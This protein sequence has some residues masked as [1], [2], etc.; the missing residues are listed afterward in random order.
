MTTDPGASVARALPGANPAPTTIFVQITDTHIREPGRLAYGRLDTAPYL[1]AAVAAIGAL[2]QAPQ[3]VVMTGDLSDFGR[4]EEYAHLAAL[5]APLTVPVYLIP[6]NH[7]T[8]AGLRQAFP[9]H[10]YLGVDGPIRYA[11]DIGGLR[12]LALDT[13]VP[14]KS[15]GEL[16]DGQLRWLDEELARCAGRPAV[17]AMH[18]PPFATLIGH[19]DKIGLL[20]G[21]EALERIVARH[22]HVERIIC[23]HVHRPIERRFGGTIASVCPSPAHQVC[24]DLQ[25]DAASAWI[26]EPP[27]FRVHALDPAGHLVSH[28]APIGRFDG[29]HPFHENGKLID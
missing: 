17:I 6:G 29:P 16:D 12:L 1:R 15:H 4:A 13:S 21:A 11:V 20:A 24:L 28:L 26:L 8:R 23:G 7:D 22:A 9:R 14:G 5:I 27:A 25:P 3:A 19:M 2:P 18:H 10:D